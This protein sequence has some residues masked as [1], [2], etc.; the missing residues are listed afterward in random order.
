[1]HFPHSVGRPG[2]R[3]LSKCR[4]IS[5]SFLNC[6]C[7]QEDT[8]DTNQNIVIVRLYF[9]LLSGMEARQHQAEGDGADAFRSFECS[10]CSLLI[11][12]EWFFL[13]FA[14][15]WK[16]SAGASSVSAQARRVVEYHQNHIAA[17]SSAVSQCSSWVLSDALPSLFVNPGSV[18]VRDYLIE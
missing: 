1:M 9:L 8:E 15:F 13:G 5:V 18:I 16:A 11:G 6:T 7:F 17:T 10:W 4:P 12:L 2:V 14:F 3:E